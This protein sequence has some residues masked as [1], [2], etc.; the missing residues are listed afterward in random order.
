MAGVR[1]EP[2][3]RRRLGVA[4]LSMAALVA[5]PSFT[6]PLI[7]QV[8]D[9]EYSAKAVETEFKCPV[10]DQCL[11]V[12]RGPGEAESSATLEPYAYR[13]GSVVWGWTRN[14]AGRPAP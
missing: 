3:R 12:A 8:G 11:G 13:I 7:H 14:S 5:L 9:R 10:E 4:V 1:K 6:Y 2:I